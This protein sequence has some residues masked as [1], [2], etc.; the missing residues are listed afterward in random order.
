MKKNKRPGRPLMADTPRRT[1]SFTLSPQLVKW[2]RHSARRNKASTSQM[3]NSILEQA[4][5]CIREHDL[6]LP[7]EIKSLSL[8][9]LCQRYGV[10]KLSIFGSALD[11]RFH[12]ESDI[13]LLVE[14]LPEKHPSLLTMAQF[15]NELSPVFGNHKVDLR[16]AEDLSSY[17]RQQVIQSAKELYHAP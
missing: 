8:G 12:P 6:N 3:L 14:F 2:L 17:F 10:S 9:Y 1:F 16:T 15:S 4:Y 5:T 13:D 7:F 11:E